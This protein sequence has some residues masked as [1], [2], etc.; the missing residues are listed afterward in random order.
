MRPAQWTNEEIKML[1][2]L[3]AIIGGVVGL[4]IGALSRTVVVAD[5]FPWKFVVLTTGAVGAI[6]GAFNRALP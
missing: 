1:Q 5:A 4:I 2:I 6:I 3:G